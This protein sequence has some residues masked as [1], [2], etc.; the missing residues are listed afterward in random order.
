MYL[1]H[2]D[3][4][5]GI[6]SITLNE[7]VKLTDAARNNEQLGVFE[8][9][10]DAIKDCIYG[11]HVGQAKNLLL[12]ICSDETADW[13]KLSKFRELQGLVRL[14]IHPVLEEVAHH[15]GVSIRI[16]SS[17]SRYA[18]VPK[19]ICVFEKFIPRGDVDIADDLQRR[20]EVNDSVAYAAIGDHEYAKIIRH[21]SLVSYQNV[22]EADCDA[23]GER[24]VLLHG[25]A[26]ATPEYA[27]IHRASRH[28]AIASS[29]KAADTMGDET[30]YEEDWNAKRPMLLR[31]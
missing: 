5:R 17:L 23:D 8:K 18:D 24:K 19:T 31:P 29:S 7:Y 27:V 26:D 25:N 2:V 10:W 4:A 15:D 12:S 21:S 14:V 16:M 9:L 3:G 30:D 6:G 22:R 28:E 11:T 1:L 13:V 20:P